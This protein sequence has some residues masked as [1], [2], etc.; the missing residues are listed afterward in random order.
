[1]NNKHRRVRL[2]TSL[3]MILIEICQDKHSIST[4]L[5]LWTFL[6]SLILNKDITFKVNVL[7]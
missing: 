6:R 7:Y 5:S 3:H 1:M 2:T 4:I